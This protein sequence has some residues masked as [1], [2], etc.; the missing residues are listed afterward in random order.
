[1]GSTWWVGVGLLRCNSFTGIESD[2]TDPPLKYVKTY[3]LYK[4]ITFAANL[5]FAWV[6]L[7]NF[8]NGTP[9]NPVIMF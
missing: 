6:S 2:G 3:A 1:M 9:P 7:K 5:L 8:Q 4:K